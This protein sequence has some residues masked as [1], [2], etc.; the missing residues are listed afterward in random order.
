MKEEKK[1]KE[2]IM[3]CNLEKQSDSPLKLK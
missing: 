2:G 3:N 1:R